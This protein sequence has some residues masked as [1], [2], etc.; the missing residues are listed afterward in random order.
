MF[1]VC[2]SVALGFVLERRLFAVCLLLLWVWSLYEFLWV[3]W[4]GMSSCLFLHAY[5]ILNIGIWLMI[6]ASDILG[7]LWCTPW[8]RVGS[9]KSWISNARFFRAKSKGLTMFGRQIWRQCLLMPLL[10]HCFV[11]ACV[12][13]AGD[14]RPLYRYYFTS[15]PL[16]IIQNSKFVYQLLT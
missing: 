16:F 4:I 9:G 14:E 15:K 5:C 12:G 3:R 1:W 7:G 11:L 13:S 6:V 2:Q 8:F 10:L